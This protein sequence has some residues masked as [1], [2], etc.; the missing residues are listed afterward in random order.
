MGNYR[1]ISRKAVADSWSVVGVALVIATVYVLKEPPR[2][3]IAIQ[4]RAERRDLQR[5][6]RRHRA[7]EQTRQD[8]L[9]DDGQERKLQGTRRSDGVNEITPDN[10]A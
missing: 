9:G 1:R 4:I 5:Q 6:G 10:P 2:Y 3:M 7:R 8:G